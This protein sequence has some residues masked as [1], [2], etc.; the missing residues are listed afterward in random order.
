MMIE[1]SRCPR[2]GIRR[3]A[4]FVPWGRYCYNCRL[5]LPLTAPPA[6][7]VYLFTEAE[8]L[9]LEW[10]RAAIRAGLYSDWRTWTPAAATNRQ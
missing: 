6:A 4:R 1:E 8:R 2:C 10:Y 3:R 9:R 7:H 5:T